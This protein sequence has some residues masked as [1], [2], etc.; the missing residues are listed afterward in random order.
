MTPMMSV[1]MGR[2]NFQIA[3]ELFQRLSC[4]KPLK[5][6]A[7]IKVTRRRGSRTS[8]FGDLQKRISVHF[9][10]ILSAG[11]F[12]KP[13]APPPTKDSSHGY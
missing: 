7:L 10:S 12:G 13:H 4:T 11:H 9:P 2:H 8:E 5:A 1:A 6:V 3:R